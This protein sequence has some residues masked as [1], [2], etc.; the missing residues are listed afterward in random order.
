MNP[1]GE[2]DFNAGHDGE[3]HSRWQAERRLAAA[4]LAHRLNLPLGHEVEVWLAGN[5]RLRGKLRL[6][7]ELLFIP[8]GCEQQLG[9]Q[10][11]QV[12]FHLGEME[13][14]VRMD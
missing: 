13:S 2:L 14:V 8:E 4:E 6:R 12:V 1:Q 7:E 3:G 9:L 11:D 5:I 10:V